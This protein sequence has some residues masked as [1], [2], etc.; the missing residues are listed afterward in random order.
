MRVLV[1]GCGRVGVSLATRLSAD[2]HDVRVVDRDPR[3]RRRLPRNFSGA[4]QPGSGFSR[5]ALHSAGIEEADVFLAV[6][7]GDSCNIVAA[8][9]AK[10]DFHV[11]IVIARVHD[12]RRA[13]VYRDLGIPTVAS[14]RW[15]VER[16]HQMLTH[17]HLS[18]EYT[19]GSGETLLVRSRL[20]GYLAGRPLDRLESDGEIRIVEVTRDGRSFI[21]ARG[22]GARADDVVSFVVTATALHRL[23]AILDKELG[24]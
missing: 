1:I 24:T 3:A 13:E 22:A 12:P 18:P 19:F 8:R 5:S 14:V 11:P 23:R 21:P 2:G 15:T 17:R 20:P 6:T 16:I 9:T 4:F 10:D 7:S